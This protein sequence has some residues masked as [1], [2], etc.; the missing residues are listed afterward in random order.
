MIEIEI[1]S[2]WSDPLDPRS[3]LCCGR[4]VPREQVPCRNAEEAEAGIKALENLGYTKEDMLGLFREHL[5]WQA[6][7]L[8]EYVRKSLS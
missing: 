2:Y 6:P 7:G 3:C 5:E 1:K 4:T 8:A